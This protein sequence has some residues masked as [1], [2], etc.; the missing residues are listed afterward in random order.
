MAASDVPM[1]WNDNQDIRFV[2]IEPFLEQTGAMKTQQISG[3]F[4]SFISAENFKSGNP[5][6]FA[7]F[8]CE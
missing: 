7:F 6:K 3:H 8:S 4:W 5:Y 2:I 1:Y